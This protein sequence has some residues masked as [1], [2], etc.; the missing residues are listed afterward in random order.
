VGDPQT[1]PPSQCIRIL[2]TLRSASAF[3]YRLRSRCSEARPTICYVP[4]HSTLSRM[5]KHGEKGTATRRTQAAPAPSARGSATKATQRARPSSS[6]EEEEAQTKAPKRRRES[7]SSALEASSSCE[8]QQEEEE[9]PSEGEKEDEASRKRPRRDEA[10]AEQGHDER[11]MKLLEAVLKEQKLA[12]LAQRVAN[13][14]S[15]AALAA[16][17]E[18]TEGKVPS[19]AQSSPLVRGTPYCF[20][21]FVYINLTCS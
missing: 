9:D 15:A 21:I 6:S 5:G 2:N 13:K 17:M 8:E 16:F 11:V 10:S 19:S 18:R 20:K 14:T 3:S 1:F 12:R 4:D 7:S